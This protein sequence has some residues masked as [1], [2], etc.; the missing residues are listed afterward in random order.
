MHSCTEHEHSCTEKFFSNN[1]EAVL[2]SQTLSDSKILVAIQRAFWGRRKSTAGVACPGVRGRDK[3]KMA[4]H[5]I[6]C[7]LA[8][9]K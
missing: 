4:A 7:N 2:S 1:I 5:K 6:V 8:E 3:M 9:L